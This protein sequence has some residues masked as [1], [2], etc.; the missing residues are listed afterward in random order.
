MPFV[1]GRRTM[2]DD[3]DDDG[4]DDEDDD[5]GDDGDT[6]D[7]GDGIR[8]KEI[9]MGKKL[10]LLEQGTLRFFKNIC[11]HKIFSSINNSHL[12]LMMLF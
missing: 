5:T 10:R 2:D 3:N 9:K 6:D 7:S 4:D 1:F 8:L 11:R 12:L